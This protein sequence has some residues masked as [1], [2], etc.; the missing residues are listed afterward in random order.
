LLRIHGA[1]WLEKGAQSLQASDE[2]VKALAYPSSLDPCRSGL[3]NAHHPQ[4][5]WS[6]RMIDFEPS[7][8]QRL[9]RESVAAFARSTLAPR[10]R[11]V[12]KARAVPDDIRR[13][14]HD[15][16]LGLVMVPESAGG[17][18]LGMVT[19]VLL[20]EELGAADAGAAFGLA[21]PQAFG[22]AVAELGTPQQIDQHLAA[23]AG[24]GGNERF[25]A[26]AWSEASPNKARAGFSTTAERSGAGWVLT[27]KKAFVVNAHLADR[28]VVF[29]QIEPDQGWG[30]LGA[31]VVPRGEGVVVGARYDTLGLDAADFGEVELRGVVV[32]D[33]ARLVGD[34]G[35]GGFT[36]ATLRFFAKRAL[37]TAARAVGLARF[38]LD[39]AREHCENRSAFGKPI[40]HFQAVAFTLADRHMDVE[41]A[42]WLV[43]KA[44]ASWDSKVKEERALHATAQAAAS[45]LEIA[46]RTADDGVGLH[47]G[48]GFI[49]DLVAEKLMRDAKQ[50]ALTCPTAEQLDQLASAIELA[51]PLDP[52]LVLP[53]PDSQAIFT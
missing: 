13:L 8:E 17:Q 5:P 33:G 43:W 26:V 41:S 19:T 38:A 45:A 32:P 11:E 47:G 12:E 49:R 1:P 31:F 2:H 51:M 44:A 25:G 15:M 18:G 24:E 36:R 14:A 20:E 50:L 37:V 40:G 39:L 4:N 3:N 9:V 48:S 10:V 29:A 6:F 7:E 21:G 27:G 30:G 34:P 23:F 52:A 42:R 46:M 22:T 28:F 53:T 16:G 35:E